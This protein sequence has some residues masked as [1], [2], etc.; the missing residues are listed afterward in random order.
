M[1]KL[2]VVIITLNEEENI[3]RCINS[4]K[5][6]ADEIIVVDS[7]STDKTCELAEKLGAKVIQHAFEGYVKQKNFAKDLAANTYVL[8]LDADEYLSGE[9]KRSIEKAKEDFVFDAYS[10]NRL[11]FYCGKPIK[12]CGWY[13]DKKIRLWNKEKVEWTGIYVHE[14]LELAKG[15]TL[16]QL[17]GDILH[18]TYPTKQD[19]LNQVDKF[20][21][22]RANELKSKNTVV[23]IL[24]LLFSAPIKF[25]RNYF[26]KLGFTDGSAGWEIC[27]HQS[28]EVF[29]KYYLA[30]KF[31]FYKG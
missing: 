11:N 26:F 25:I 10:M 4:V 6:L 16:A 28:R 24:K 19:L 18:D 3:T 27:Y 7:F 30:L 20:A 8:S 2:S 5:E 21:T 12:T 22:Y 23:L 29:L 17:N 1:N 15:S 31:K 13:P 9:L 14:Q